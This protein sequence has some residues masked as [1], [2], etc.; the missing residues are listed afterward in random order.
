MA[1]VVIP[2]YHSAR[3][4]C[5]GL[6]FTGMAGPKSLPQTKAHALAADMLQTGPAS[7]LAIAI[8]FVGP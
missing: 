3:W 5:G 6:S 8:A 1:I 2:S 7:N 4:S